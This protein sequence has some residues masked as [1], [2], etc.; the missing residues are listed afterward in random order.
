MVALVYPYLGSILFSCLGWMA[1][2][3]LRILAEE[4][5]IVAGAEPSAV[6]GLLDSWR[7]RYLLI[8]HLVHQMSRY[9]GFVLL[10]VITTEF[11]R[12]TSTSF[13]LLVDYQSDKWR[14]S[15]IL[16]T[17]DFLKET[18]CFFILL[19]IPSRIRQEV[20]ILH[21]S[22]IYISLTSYGLFVKYLKK[23][24]GRRLDKATPS[25]EL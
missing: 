22:R 2:A 8:V 23:K 12:M 9:F 15:T 3:M 5:V 4:I 20:R 6:G 24:K 25:N 11:V 10:V 13:F 14:A 7:R 16:M 19:Y 18:T 17:F 1:S 21:E